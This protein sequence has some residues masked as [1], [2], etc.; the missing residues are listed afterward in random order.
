MVMMSPRGIT[1]TESSSRRIPMIK[2]ISVNNFRGVE[3]LELHGLR[4]INVIVGQNASGKTALL[5]SIFLAAG[6]SPEIALRMSAQRGLPLALQI[7][8]DRSSYESLWRYLFYGL[9]HKKTISIQLVGDPPNTRSVAI[10]Y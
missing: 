7:T 6:G 8:W 5:E 1:D 4:R 9:D 10:A 3:A 2:S